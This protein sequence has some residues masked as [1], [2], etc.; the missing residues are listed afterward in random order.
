VVYSGHGCAQAKTAVVRSGAAG[1]AE[2]ECCCGV[3]AAGR[4][5]AAGEEGVVEACCCA[6]AAL[7]GWLE[8]HPQRAVGGGSG[9]CFCLWLRLGPGRLT[10]HS[11][12]AY[13]RQ[14]A[15]AAGSA[16]HAARASGA[17]GAVAP[18]HASRSCSGTFSGAPQPAAVFGWPCCVR[19]GG[20]H[21]RE[22]SE[23]GGQV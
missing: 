8:S 17:S 6:A 19:Q 21:A 16:E 1:V 7:Q 13:Q 2:G 4:F 22:Q 23:G 10:A 20:L 11:G 18:V 3:G 12:R 15:W 14:Q 9:S 5:A